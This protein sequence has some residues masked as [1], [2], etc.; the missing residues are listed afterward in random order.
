MD[1]KIKFTILF[2]LELFYQIKLSTHFLNKGIFKLKK[3][4]FFCHLKNLQKEKF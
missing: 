1:H 2:L 4:Q 3:F